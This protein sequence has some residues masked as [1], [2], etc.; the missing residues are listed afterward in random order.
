M[1]SVK[2][3][4]YKTNSFGEIDKSKS[5]LTYFE[6]LDLE[7]FSALLRYVKLLNPKKMV[8]VR[9]ENGESYIS[10]VDSSSR[11]HIKII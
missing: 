10:V 5:T 3:T 11:K 1:I 4:E 7:D 2:I 6:R 8:N 9:Y